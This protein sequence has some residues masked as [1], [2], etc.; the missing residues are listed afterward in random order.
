MSWKPCHALLAAGFS[1]NSLTFQEFAE[2]VSKSTRYPAVQLS[3]SS[4]WAI[5]RKA[6]QYSARF[7]SILN[8]PVLKVFRTRPRK[9]SLRLKVAQTPSSVVT[10]YKLAC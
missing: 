6:L 1:D 4:N 2:W 3:H 10:S 7:E 5:R 9:P 8:V